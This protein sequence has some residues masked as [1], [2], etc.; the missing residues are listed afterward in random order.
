VPSTNKEE[1]DRLVKHNKVPFLGL[2]LTVMKNLVRTVLP[3]WLLAL[4][5]VHWSKGLVHQ[6]YANP[7]CQDG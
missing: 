4:P 3:A 1:K 6:L 5:Q 2:P 7:T